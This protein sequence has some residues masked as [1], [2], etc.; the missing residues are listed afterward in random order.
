M[1]TTQQ[2]ADAYRKQQNAIVK[3]FLNNVGRRI[4]TDIDT[5]KAYW[6]AHRRMRDKVYPRG[7]NFVLIAEGM[8]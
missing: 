5:R 2:L 7:R 8:I 6:K 1:S 4:E 3:Q